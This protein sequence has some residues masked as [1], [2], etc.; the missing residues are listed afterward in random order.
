ML[1]HYDVD[2]PLKLFWDASPHGVVM[3]I[4]PNG[5]EHPIVYA[6]CALTSSG[7]NYAQIEWEA[8][9]GYTVSTSTYMVDYL[10][11]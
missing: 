5:D 10:L 6:S 2:K 7:F 9:L 4:M 8:F 3:S 11:W 1:V